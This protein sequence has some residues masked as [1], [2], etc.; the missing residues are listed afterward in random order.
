MSRIIAPEVAGVGNFQGKCAIKIV[1]ASSFR[2]F[3]FNKS[4]CGTS[5][6]LHKMP[7]LQRKIQAQ[8]LMELHFLRFR[9]PSA[10]HLL[11]KLSP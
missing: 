7:K 9:S 11:S 4:S 6:P 5:A 1:A 10:F 2:L 8:G 3:E